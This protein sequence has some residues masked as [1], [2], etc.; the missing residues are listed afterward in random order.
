[1]KR[2]DNKLSP[3]RRREERNAWLFVLPVV[4]GILIFNVF[5]VLFSL[6]TSFTRWNLLNPPVW[7][8]LQN[9]TD[10]F[11][12]DPFFFSTL[13][14][15]VV[16]ALGTVF[17]GIVLSLLVAML[18]NLKIAGQGI[19]RAIFFMPVVVPTTAAALAWVWI[20]DPSSSGILNGFLK[21]FEISPI[22]WL[23]NGRYA[24]LSVIIEALW[25]SFGLN[26]VIF[27]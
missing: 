11:T 25:A 24:L 21:F 14:N 5:P 4:V 19:F 8:N 20:Y 7:V 26:T 10:L 18:L 23:T 12:T 15:T 16:Y 22:P 9:Y 2:R 6:Y 1:M 13:R 3:E 27:L 17:I